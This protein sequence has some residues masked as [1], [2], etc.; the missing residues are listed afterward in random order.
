[1]RE[2]TIGNQYDG[3]LLKLTDS[4]TALGT[5]WNVHHSHSFSKIYHARFR[6]DTYQTTITKQPIIST[7]QEE[8]L[9]E[10]NEVRGRECIRHHFTLAV[11][12]KGK[13][14]NCVNKVTGLCEQSIW[15]L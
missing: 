3:M 7:Q 6:T 4:I 8:S 13:Q 11:C 14:I 12:E 10:A 9:Y 15:P 2:F 1:M 5:E